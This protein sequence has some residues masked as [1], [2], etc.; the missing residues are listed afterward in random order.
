MKILHSIQECK[1]WR[2]SSSGSVGFVPTMG[3]LHLGHISLVK[4]SKE[5]CK[6]TIVSIFINPA[7]FGPNEDLSLYPKTIDQD[8]KYLK[9]EGVDA[10]FIPTSNEIYNSKNDECFFDTPLS[11]KLEGITRPHFFKGVTMVVNKLF[12]IVMPTHVVFGQKDAQQLI[13]IKKMIENKNLPIKMLS[14]KTVRKNS[15]LALSS[16]NSYLSK[17]DQNIASNIYKGLMQIKEMLQKEITDANKLKDNFA[18]F[19]NSFAGFKIDYISIAN[20]NTLEEVK[21]VNGSV[22]IS[23][24]VFFKNVRLID[25]FTYSST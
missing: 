9:Q 22:L 14:G 25:N 5:N 7:Q 16:R 19:I 12:N 23:T 24:A 10:V 8:L 6:N 21:K 2:A 3:A 20:L 18:R 13:I 15:G 4:I 17:K 11:K 1:N